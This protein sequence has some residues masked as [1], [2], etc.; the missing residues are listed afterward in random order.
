MYT[1][2]WLFLSNIYLPLFWSIASFWDT[3]FF[4]IF[5]FVWFDSLRPINNRSVIKGQVFLGWTSTKLGLM[6]LLKNTVTPVRLEPTALRSRVKHSTTEPLRSHFHMVSSIVV[7]WQSYSHMESCIVSWQLSLSWSCS[8][9]CKA[10]WAV[11]AALMESSIVSW[12]SYSHME[13][14]IVSWQLSL[15]WSCSFFCKAGWAVIAALS[16]SPSDN[17]IFCS[18]EQ[19]EVVSFEDLQTDH[20]NRS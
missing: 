5:C 20:H 13:S 16:V 6:F 3:D 14:C 1:N 11:I 4:H 7:S 18:T 19:S 2:I 8:F 17:S 15:S 9:F 12:Q 10:G